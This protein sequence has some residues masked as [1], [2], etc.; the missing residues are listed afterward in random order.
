[1]SYIPPVCQA[2]STESREQVR[3]PEVAEWIGAT[4]GE[5]SV[6]EWTPVSA[7][8][9]V[10][11]REGFERTGERSSQ[12]RN[13]ATV[14]VYDGRR[15]GLLGSEAAVSILQELT[16][17]SGWDR[18]VSS[19]LISERVTSVQGQLKVHFLTTG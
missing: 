18:V 8:R 2:F 11:E 15:R 16:V 10:G 17:R 6:L 13:L 19:S 5:K 12:S 7:A 14:Q 9:S 4:D 1:M 3:S